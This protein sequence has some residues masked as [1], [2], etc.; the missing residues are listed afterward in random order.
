LRDRNAP[1]LAHEQTQTLTTPIHEEEIFQAAAAMP[2]GERAAYL[3][4][5]CGA[6]L[7]LRVRIERLLASHEG[8]EFMQPALSSEM[9]EQFA[10]LK[11]E[12]SGELIGSYKLREQIGEGGFGTVWVA[13][14]EKPVR[15]RVAL[16]IIKMGMD[17]KEVIARFEQERQALAM[18]DHPNIARVF[19]AG[20]TQWGRPFPVLR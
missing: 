10:R 7:T 16:K 15:R 3:D 13:D 17:T 6:D 9:E 2:A 5:V 20:A 18:M 4:A 19:D 12:E 11:P 1:Q 14:Q 8:S